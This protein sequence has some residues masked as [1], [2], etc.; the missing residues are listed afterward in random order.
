MK[1]PLTNLV[2]FSI[3]ILVILYNHL[4]KIRMRE[5]RIHP[6]ISADDFQDIIYEKYYNLVARDFAPNQDLENA[7]I[8]CVFQVF[9][10]AEL[11]QKIRQ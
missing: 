10:T 6:P 1:I 11:G 7:D 8:L 9:Q 4:T 2:F 5:G 3:S